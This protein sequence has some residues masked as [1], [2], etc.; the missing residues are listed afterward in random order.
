MVVLSD[1]AVCKPQRDNFAP[2]IDTAMGSILLLL[3]GGGTRVYAEAGAGGLLAAGAGRATNSAD[4][5]PRPFIE[6]EVRLI[7][8][9]AILS[10][11]QPATL[12]NILLLKQSLTISVPGVGVP[13]KDGDRFSLFG[14][15]ALEV[16]E[17]Y[18]DYLTVVLQR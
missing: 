16:K 10:Y 13:L 1:I 7:D 9:S 17:A 3:F 5:F 2:R 12:E 15:Q 6:F 8:N 11:L 4:A 18:K 14:Q